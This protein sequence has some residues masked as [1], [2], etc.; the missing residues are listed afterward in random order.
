MK[1]IVSSFHKSNNI[2]D[3]SFKKMGIRKYDILGRYLIGYPC[4]K[5]SDLKTFLILPT[6]MNINLQFQKNAYKYVV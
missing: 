4:L 2:R 6:L 5:S 1:A 3:V